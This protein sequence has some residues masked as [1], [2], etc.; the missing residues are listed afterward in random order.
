M[1][2][3]PILLQIILNDNYAVYFS[4]IFATDTRPL[5]HRLSP[6]TFPVPSPVYLSSFLL[7]LSVRPVLFPVLAQIWP[8][9]LLQNRFSSGEAH[10]GQEKRC[11]T[12]AKKYA[13][14]FHTPSHPFFRLS[15]WKNSHIFRPHPWYFH[16]RYN[17]K[18]S[19]FTTPWRIFTG[20]EYKYT[21]IYRGYLGVVNSQQKYWIHNTADRRKH[22]G[23]CYQKPCEIWLRWN[24]IVQIM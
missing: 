1:R 18:Y 21:V 6:I 15:N 3:L 5:Y 16:V 2:T 7:S 12:Y 11:E 10:E 24:I 23:C 19:G 8:I 14:A 17:S 20:L 13:I 9:S 4:K 22:L